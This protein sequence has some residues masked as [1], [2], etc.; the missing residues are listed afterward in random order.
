MSTNRLLLEQYY[1]IASFIASVIGPK[2]EVVIHDISKPEESIVHIENGYISGRK[3][4][5]GSTDLVLKMIK[6]GRYK[7]QSYI[8]NYRAVG[9]KNE[10]Y[11]SS[12]YF[13]KDEADELVGMMCLNIDISHLTAAAEWIDLLI[14]GGSQEMKPAKAIDTNVATEYLQGNVEELLQHM[15]SSTLDRSTVPADRMSSHEKLEWMKELNEQGVFLLK[16]G[17]SQVAKALCV[18]EPTVYRY[19]NKLKE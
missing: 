11:R 14:H 12:T 6:G 3:P 18:S 4:G 13:I 17:V 5:D 9:P 10:I 8:T 19:L 1:P 2:C 15:I 7:K 16:G